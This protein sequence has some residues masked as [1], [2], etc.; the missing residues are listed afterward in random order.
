MKKILVTGAYG[1]IGR[2]TAKYFATAGW[3]VIGIG[4]GRWQESEWKQWG[5]S[6]WYESDLTVDALQTY[7][8]A[9]DVIVH[10]AGSGVVGFSLEH[11][12]QDFHRTVNGTVAVLEFVRRTNPKAHVIYTS[13]AGVYGAA[14]KMPIGEYDKLNPISPYGAHKKLA[15]EM[16]HSY[17]QY[18]GLSITIVRLFSVYGIGL[19]KQLLWDACVKITNGKNIFFGDGKEKRDWLH[20]YDA[21]KLLYTIAARSDP[22]FKIIN[23]GTGEGVSVKEIL[24]ELYLCFDR[25]DTPDFSGALRDGDPINYIANIDEALKLNWMPSI[26]WRD[27]V[28]EYVNWFRDCIK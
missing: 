24:V 7:V 12:E 27:G 18:F 10:C 21:A 17:Y 8:D 6:E 26:S 28:Y 13:S 15:E 1:F 4:H 5:L 23:G 19:R 16:C 3:Q 11:P 9:V 22:G 2:N 25:T 14:L 20:I